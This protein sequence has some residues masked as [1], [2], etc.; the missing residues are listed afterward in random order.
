MCVIQMG[1]EEARTVTQVASIRC[2]AFEAVLRVRELTGN[3]TARNLE[4]AIY[5]LDLDEKGEKN[6]QCIRIL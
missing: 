3:T 1:T 6:G 4:S 5:T 2:L